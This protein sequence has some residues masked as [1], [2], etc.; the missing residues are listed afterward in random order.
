MPRLPDAAVLKPYL[1]PLLVQ[2]AGNIP[3]QMFLRRLRAETE[4]LIASTTAITRTVSGVSSIEYTAGLQVQTIEYVEESRPA[5]APAGALIDR[6]HQLIV[7][8]VKGDLAALCAS[9][10]SFRRKLGQALTVARP[11]A[12][13][14]VEQAFVGDRASVLW[15]NGVHT[16]TDT[17]P[18]A[19]TLM[20]TALEYA[21]DPLGDQS[22][23]YAAVRSRVSLVSGGTAKSSVLVGAS[24]GSGRIW[25]NRPESW[26]VFLVDLE[27]AELGLRLLVA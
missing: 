14:T 9:D 18:N 19:K 10:S 23:Y 16:P 3:V 4:G 25:V 24:P 17:R 6:N 2:R 8:A 21:L 15:L 26:P 7:I 13:V 22:F 20:G 27:A 12:R 5:W 11:I 1:A